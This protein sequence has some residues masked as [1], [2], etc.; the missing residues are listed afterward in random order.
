M[1][2]PP[3]TWLPNFI[4]CK[5]LGVE[6]C[7]LPAAQFLNCKLHTGPDAYQHGQERI[8]LSS[9]HLPVRGCPNHRRLLNARSWTTSNLS[10]LCFGIGP[11][12]LHNILA[13][14]AVYEA[15]GSN[16]LHKKVE[17]SYY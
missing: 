17:V 8:Q 12:L 16:I 15:Y 10:C 9:V 13:V 4:H 11:V 7:N 14:S 5:L 2:Y 1:S 6:S 3:G